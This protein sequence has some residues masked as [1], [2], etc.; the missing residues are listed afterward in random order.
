MTK[1]PAIRV[2]MADDHPLIREGIGAL[3]SG[4]RD[5]DVVGEASDGLQ[6]VALYSSLMPD[7]LLLDL[8]MPGLG[9][10]EAIGVIKSRFP[11]ARII[12]LTTYEGDQLASKA[13]SA[14]AQ[15]Y[16][17]KSSVRTELPDTIRA[18]HRGQKHIHAKVAQNLAQHASDDVLTPREVDVLSL[19]ARGNSNRAVGNSLSITEETVKG[20]VK[21]ILSKLGAK[22]RT[23]AVALALKR[24]IIE[25]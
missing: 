1:G 11:S 5:I 15:A 16:L 2:V 20:Y 14:G 18:V 12:V 23:H 10:L 25:L 4:H 24:G 9:G 21:N 6:A 3:L 19:I 13:I 17:L 8:Q 22:D 7:I